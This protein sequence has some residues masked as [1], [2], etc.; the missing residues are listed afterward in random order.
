LRL[1]YLA[2]TLLLWACTA[3]TVDSAE[4]SSVTEP[5]EVP[6]ESVGDAPEVLFTV[7]PPPGTFSQNVLVRLEFAG[8]EPEIY[9]TLDGTMPDDRDELYEGPITIAETTTLR[10]VATNADGDPIGNALVASYVH[11]D[12]A[13][14]D[15]TS[16]LPLVVLTSDEALPS[17]R[18]AEH[19]AFAMQIYEP[20]EDGRASFVGEAD[21]DVR[22]GLKVRG[23]S[24]SSFPKKPYGLEVWSA[25]DDADHSVEILGMPAESDWVLLS[26]LVFDRALMRNALIYELSRDIGRYAPRTRFVEVFSADRSRDLDEDDY[27][28]VY[29]LMER[30]KRDPERVAITGL[31]EDDIVEPEVTGGYMWKED[32]L[33]EGESGFTAGTAGGTF[34]F[35]QRF[36]LVD[37]KEEEV[38]S[39]QENY[40]ED[41]LDDFGDTLN[42]GDS[43]DAFIDADAFVDH[44]I[45][46]TYAKN[47]DAF[48]L[49]GYFHKDR[50]GLIHAGPIWDFDRTMGCAQDWRASEPTWWDPTNLT[51]DT[52][53]FFAHGWWLGLFSDPDFTALWVQRWRS[54][55]ANELSV[56]T[57]NA[58]VDRMAAELSEA[59]PRNFARWS[60]YPPRD[61]GDFAYEVELLKDWLTARHA[62]ISACIEGDDPL[63]CTG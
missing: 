47:P 54:V 22:M 45:L 33:A 6:V 9:Y 23:S 2:M 46:N 43:V 20:G 11:L 14:D 21:L 17:E 38:R 18:R 35:Q 27:L 49:S 56:E 60:D 19:T 16:N 40:L 37:P 51:T 62:W 57:V 10:A 5:D 15:F 63:A 52:T 44:H 13:L 50:E 4:D 39:Q 28:G 31:G 25:E 3:T 26:P 34:T 7:S 24:S 29:V 12:S 36:V 61:G 30:I 59:A 1:P 41:L 32:R 58:K 42:E 8:A 48:R 55:L 53:D